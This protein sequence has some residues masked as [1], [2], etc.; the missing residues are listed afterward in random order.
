MESDTTTVAPVT[1]EYCA[2]RPLSQ[3]TASRR[4]S[5]G[6]AHFAPI[7]GDQAHPHRPSTAPA[8]PSSLAPV[9]VASHRSGGRHDGDWEC[10]W[11]DSATGQ[12]RCSICCASQSAVPDAVPRHLDRLDEFRLL[13]RPSAVEEYLDWRFPELTKRWF[14]AASGSDRSVDYRPCAAANALADIW[15]RQCDCMS[16]GWRERAARNWR[17]FFDSVVEEPSTAPP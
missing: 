11:D 15:R 4:F 14:P 5:P 17:A 7:P 12:V 1:G 10:S 3:G 6:N 16:E 2:Y 13:P 8:A 9:R